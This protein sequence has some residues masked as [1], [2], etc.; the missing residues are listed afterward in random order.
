MPCQSS[1]MEPTV[2]ELESIRLQEFFQEIDGNIYDHKHPSS[3]PNV[4]LIDFHTRNLCSWCKNHDVSKM[5]LE[6][7]MWWRDHQE[8]DR[9]RELEE[10]EKARRAELRKSAYQKLTQDEIEALRH[11]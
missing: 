4:N 10:K 1:Y 5:S 9:V 6:L 8:A 7:Q 11:K 3:R 2:R